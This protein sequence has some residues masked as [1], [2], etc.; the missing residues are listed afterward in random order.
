[1]SFTRKQALE[2]WHARWL[3][4]PIKSLVPQYAA[5]P[6]RFYEVWEE[7]VHPGTRMEAFADFQAKYP[8]T[9]R[10]VSPD[11]HVPTRHV[12]TRETDKNQLGLFD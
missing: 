8:S 6:R 2:I 3:K 11:P 9:A 12:V 4:I 5:D 10:N 7:Q 1:M